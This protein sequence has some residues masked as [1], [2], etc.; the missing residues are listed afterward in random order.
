MT[1]QDMYQHCKNTEKLAAYICHAEEKS[2]SGMNGGP[3]GPLLKINTAISE[4]ILD[5]LMDQRLNSWP[6]FKCPS[7]DNAFREI[8][9]LK[10]DKPPQETNRCFAGK[11]GG[12]KPS[13]LKVPNWKKGSSAAGPKKKRE[14]WRR[15]NCVVNLIRRRSGDDKQG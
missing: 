7:S 3:F 4:Q 5:Y 13:R 15:P 11:G 14:D 12:K 6:N 2:S 1:Q 8:C 9:W 10:K